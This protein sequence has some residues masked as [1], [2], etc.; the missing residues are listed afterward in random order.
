MTDSRPSL[1]RRPAQ[2]RVRSGRAVRPRGL[3]LVAS[4]AAF[5]AVAPAR[6]SATRCSLPSRRCSAT[7]VVLETNLQYAVT[8]GYVQAGISGS[9]G[10]LTTSGPPTPPDWSASRAPPACRSTPLSTRPDRHCLGSFVLA[11]GA[12]SR[13]SERRAPEPTTSGSGRR[14]RST[15]RPACS[16]PRPRCPR[17]GRRATPPRAGRASEKRLERPAAASATRRRWHRAPGRARERSPCHEP[18]SD[19]TR[20]GGR[21]RTRCARPRRHPPRGG[22]ATACALPGCR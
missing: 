18:G 10:N 4:A 20:P 14:Q 5:L 1:P 3:G 16:R 6:R 7:D 19:A 11:P 2:R 22:A 9:S 15:A 17:D 13:C 21:P 8:G 12:P